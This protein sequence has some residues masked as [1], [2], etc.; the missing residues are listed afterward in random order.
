MRVRQR[1]SL[2]HG[3]DSLLVKVALV[4]NEHLINMKVSVL[5]YLV[6]PIIH[7]SKALSVR[8]VIAQ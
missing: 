5:L 2:F 8:H 1:L 6:D 4:P 3:H 7:V